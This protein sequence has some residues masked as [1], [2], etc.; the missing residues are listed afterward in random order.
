MTID[1]SM[2]F[3]VRQS[4]WPRYGSRKRLLHTGHLHPSHHA[5]QE[6]DEIF[7]QGHVRSRAFNPSFSCPQLSYPCLPFLVQCL[8]MFSVQHRSWWFTMKTNFSCRREGDVPKS[9]FELF[10]CETVSKLIWEIDKESNSLFKM[11]TCAVVEAYSPVVSHT[12]SGI[13]G[14]LYTIVAARQISKRL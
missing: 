9:A 1:W 6:E 5:D 2:P 11:I 8:S 10:C 14:F 4:L 12:F 3:S 7:H 13:Q